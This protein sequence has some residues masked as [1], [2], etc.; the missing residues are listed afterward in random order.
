M[1]SHKNIKND[2][3]KL[4]MPAVLYVTTNKYIYK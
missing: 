4:D 3:G 2:G 1:T